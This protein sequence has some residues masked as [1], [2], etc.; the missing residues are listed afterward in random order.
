MTI[1]KIWTSHPLSQ[2]PK[3]SFAITA[4]QVSLS[5]LQGIHFN[6]KNTM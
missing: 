6:N 5:T 4:F 2:A 3:S 1:Y